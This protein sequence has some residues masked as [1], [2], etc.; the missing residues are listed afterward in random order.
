M[1]IFSNRT[2]QKPFQLSHPSQECKL[3]S[4]V[5]PVYNEQETI[6]L[7][8]QKLESLSIDCIDLIQLEVI[9]ID[10]CSQDDTPNQIKQFLDN[11][12]NKTKFISI[13]HDKNRGKGGA[14]KTGFANATGDI[15]IV[16]DAD[17][18]YDS[19]EIPSVIEPILEG[20]ADVVYGS[21]FMVKKASRVLYYY[22]FLAN[23]FLTFLSNLF[24]NMNMTDIE[25][26]YKAFRSEII[27][28]MIIHSW[29]FGFEVEVTAKIAKLNC[30]VY[31]VPIS[32]YGRTYEEG[33]KI[34]LMDG[35]RAIF[36][37]FYYNLFVNQKKSFQKDFLSK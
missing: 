2:K 19:N 23:K 12:E 14:V 10:D 36:L 17:L 3:L 29:G 16:Q 4:I 35:V 22:H 21:R 9:I 37:I 34:G 27:K 13:R 18:E 24:T 33:K 5:I 30:R 7:T 25:T 11:S 15:I 31:E 6:E 20:K 28:N 32:Y 1:F 8:L 26:G